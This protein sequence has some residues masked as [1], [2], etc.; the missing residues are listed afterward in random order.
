MDNEE[1]LRHFLKR[2]T[3]ELQE[4]REKLREAETADQEPIAIVGLGCRFPG[5][6][7]SPEALWELLSGGRDAITEFPDDRGWDVD[8]LHDA[9]GTTRGTSYVRHGGFLHDA[10]DFDPAFF[11]I[12]PREALVMDPQQRLMLEISW[13]AIERAGIDPAA[14]RGSSTGVFTGTNFQDYIH[15]A[16]SA[17]EGAEDYLSTANASSVLSGRVAYALGLE[18]PAIT[19]DTACSA[20]LV[21]MHLAAHALR[22]GDC[23]LALAGGATI[24]ATPTLFIA[25]SRQRGL[26]P[27]GRC[28]SFAAGAE[29][30]GWGEGAGV[31]VLERLSDAERNGHRIL[32]VMRGSAVNQD[33]ASNGLTAPSGP[34][35]ERVIRAALAGAGLTPADVD[36]VE[37]HGTGTTLGDPIEARALAATYGRDRTGEPLWLGS[38]KSNLGHTQAAAGVAGVLKMVLALQHGVL[39]ETLGVDA[40]TPALDWDSSGLALVTGTRAWPETGRPRRAGVSSF[41]LSGTNAHI[42]LEQAPAIPERESS[43]DVRVPGVLNWPLAGKNAA[44]LRAQAARLLSFVDGEV[45]PLD[46]AYS[47][48]TTRAALPHRAVVTGAGLDDL[49]QGLAALAAGNGT[50]GVAAAGAVAFLFTGQGAQRVGMGTELYQA[51]PVFAE[52][53]DAACAHLDPALTDVVRGA[54]NLDDTQYAQAA[55]FALEVALFRL[56]ESWG[57]RPDYLLGHSVG[58]IAAAHVAGVFSLED[59]GALVSA[60]GRLMQ[61]LPAGGAMLAAEIPEAEALEL[62]AG[63]EASVSLAAINGPD[64]VVLSGD[65]TAI[66]ELAAELTARGRRTK[67]LRVSHAFHS[68]LMEPMLG[69]FAAVARG[70]TYGEARIPVVSNR[71]GRV[72]TPGELQDPAYWVSHV[73]EAVRFGDGV[74]WL[75]ERDVTRFVELG[76]DGVLSAMAQQTVSDDVRCVPLLRSGRPEEQ[77]VATAVAALHVAGVPVDWA[78]FY[79]GTGAERM[80]LPTYA[81]QHERYWPEATPPGAAATDPAGLGLTAAGHPL[82][83]TAIGLADGEGYLFT[84][85]LTAAATPWLADHVIMGS[86]LLPG[87]AF[88]ELAVRAGDSVGCPQVAELTLEAP[89]VVP[90]RGGVRLQLIVGAADHAGRRPITVHSRLDDEPEDTAWERHASGVLAPGEPVTV[91]AAE[92]WP[93]AGAD[94]IDITGFYD[95]LASV[96]F[97]YGPA[98]QG[99][100]RVWRRGD[101]VFAEVSRPRQA[102]AADSYGL[103][104][105]LLDAALHALGAAGRAEDADRLLPFAWSGVTLHAAGASALRVRIDA[106]NPVSVSL[107]VSDAAG[108][109]VATVD[110]LALR[111]VSTNTGR[112]A[113]H[114]SLFTVEWVPVPAGAAPA[115]ADWPALGADFG[116]EIPAHVRYTPVVPDGETPSAVREAV[117]TALSTVQDW[118]A[119]ERFARSRLVVVTHGDLVTAPLWGL[120]GSAQAEQ[121]DRIT[122]VELDDDP[123]SAELLS[124]AVALGEPKIAIREGKLCVPRLARA[125]VTADA[126]PVFDET[127]TVLVTGGL[128]G[129][130]GQV[131]RH[132]VTEHGVRRLLLLGRRGP[133]TPGADRLCAD[134][135]EL[136]ADATALACDVADRDALT[137]VFADHEITAVVHT[138]GVLADATFPSLTGE[139]VDAVLRPKVDAAWHLHELTADRP[140]VTAFVLFSSVAGVFGAAGQGNYAAANAF[141]DALA[142]HRRTQGLPAVSLAWGAWAPWESEGGNLGMAGTL[143]DADIERMTRAGTPPLALD[144]ALSLFDAAL[145]ADDALLAPVRLDL[146]TLS[147]APEVPPLLRRLVRGS[148]RRRPKADSGLTAR[149]AALAPADRQRALV[150]LVRTHVVGLLGYSSI[151]QVE[152]AQSFADLGFDS[153]SAVELRNAVQAETGLRLP[154]TLVFDYP[155][156]LALARHLHDELVG[157]LGSLDAV[158]RAP[159]RTA[160]AVESDPVVI[161]SMGC[162]YPGGITSPDELWD[163]VVGDGDG[164]SR[165]PGDRGWPVDAIYHPDPDHAGTSYTRDG[166]FLDDVAG[167]DPGFFGIS[168][169]EAL[170]MDPQQRQLLETS[171]EALERAGIRPGT[172]RGSRTGVYAGIMYHD[173]LGA[174]VEFPADSLGYLGT[175]NAGSVLSGRISYVFGLEGPSVTVDT[176][177][178]SS[179][180][181]L[182]MAATALQR[183]ECELA[184]AGGVTVMATPGT[185]ID[186]SRQRGL[187]ADGRCKSYADSADG[188]GWSEGVGVLV[189]ERLS[190]ARRNGHPVLA[191]VRGS[192]VNSDGASNGLTAPNGPSQQRVIRQA[193]GAAGLTP[194][195]VD[196]VEGHGTGTTLGDPIEAQALLATYGQERDEFQPLL[197][198]SVKSNLGHTQAAAGVAGVIKSVLA[199]RAGIVPKSL[200]IDAPSSHVDWTAGDIQLVTDTRPWPETGRPRRAAVSSFGISGTNAHVV[201]EQAPAAEPAPVVTRDDRPAPWLLAA[202]TPEALRAQA[203]RLLTAVG[204]ADARD[205]A[206]SLAT[207]RTAFEYRAVLTGDPVAALTALA[208]GED[209]PLPATPG[210]RTAFLFT[211]QGAQ[212][213]GA[214]RELYERFPAFAAALDDVCAHLDPELGF[215]LRE[216]MFDADASLEPTDV[217][218]PA[219][220]AIEVALYRLLRS[221]GVTPDL[222]LGHSIG[223]LAAAH[224]AG[225]F[226]LAD[227]SRLVA[228][229]GRLMAALPATGA[230]VAINA[231]EEAVAGA[232]E[233]RA[234]V[235][236]AAVNGPESVVLSGDEDAVTE[237]TATFVEAGHRTSRLKVSHAFHS[238]LMDPMLD[239]F[240]AIAETIEYAPAEVPVVS[241]LTGAIAGDELGTADYWVRHVREAVRFADGVA[242][243]VAD[244]VTAFLEVGPAGVLSAMAAAVLPA[245]AV[246]V[247]ALRRDREDIE[248]VV[249]ALSALHRHG[250]DVD[251]DAYFVGGH[252]LAL[253]TYAFQHERF[254]PRMAVLPGDVGAIGLGAVAHPLLGGGIE[255]PESGGF[256]FTAR[257]S[258]ATHPWLAGHRIAGSVLLPGT[259]LLELAVCAGDQLGCPGV[260][261]LTLE[262]PLVLADETGT[263][264]QVAVGPPDEAGD[265]PVTVYSRRED[266]IDQPWTRH[267]SGTLLGT[268]EPAPEPVGRPGNADEVDLTALYDGFADQGFEYGPAFRGLTA[269]WRHGEDVYAEVRLPEDEHADAASFGLHPALLDACLHATSFSTAVRP[270]SLPFAWEGVSVHAAGATSVLVRV[271]PAG[272]DAVALQVTDFDGTPVASV[273]SLV[274]RPLPSGAVDNTADRDSLFQLD[275]IPFTPGAPETGAVAVAGVDQLG[276]AGVFPD[277]ARVSGLLA[278]D[279]DVPPFVV[280]PVAGDENAEVVQETHELT[281]HVLALLQDWLA[282]ERFTAARLV[283]VTRGATTG[284]D[285]PAAAVWGLARTAQVEHPGRIVLVDLDGTAESLAALPSALGAGEPQVT[286]V[287]GDLRAARLTR[288]EPS[289]PYESATASHELNG[290]GDPD[291]T[292]LITGGTGGLGGLLARHLVTERGARHLLLVSRRGLAADGAPELVAD[293][294]EAGADVEVRSCDIADRDALRALL[295]GIPAEHPLTAVV[296]TAGVLDDGVLGSLT[297]ERLATVLRPKVDAAWN[298]HELTRDLDLAA[299]VSFSSVAGTFGGAGQANYAAANAFLDALALRR[300]G[301]GRPAQSLGWGPWAAATGMTRALSDA[302][303][304]RMARL[305]MPVLQ[306]EQSI[307]LFDRALSTD[308]AVL[309]PVRLDLPVIRTQPEIPP[310]LRG[311]VRV[312]GRRLAG[313]GPAAAGLV[314]RLAGLSE[315]ER[316]EA[317]LDLVRGQVALVLGHADAAAIP[318]AKTFQELGFDSLT[319]VDLRNK[320]T[321]ASGVALPATTVFDYPTMTALARHLTG[322]LAGADDD[323]QDATPAVAA[324]LDEPIA[325]VAMSCRYPGGVTTPEQLWELVTGGTD[326]ITEFPSDRG[327]DVDSLYDPDPDHPGTSYTR[328]GGFLHDAAEFDAAFF[329]MS[330]REAVA[331]DTQQRLLLEVSWEAIERAGIDPRVLRGSRTGVFAGVM[332][333]DYNSL[334]SGGDLEA[335]QG[336]GSAG[337]VASGRVSY[338]LGLEGPAVTVDTACSSSL[339]ALHWAAQALRSGECTLALAGGVTVMSTPGTFVGFSR[340]RGLSADGR[341]KSF[342]DDADGVGWSEGAGML[343]LERLSDARRNGHPVLAVVKGSA[344]NSDGASNGLTAPNGPSQQRVIRQALAASG[345][346]TSDVDVVEGHGTGTTLGDPIEAQALLATYGRDRETPLLLGSVKS[347]IGHTQAAAGVAGII[348]MVEALRHG[349]VPPSLHAGEVSTHV[350]WAAGDVEVVTGNRPWPE[351]GRARRAAVSSFGISG[352]NAHTIIEQAPDTNL[353]DAPPDA[354]VVPWPLS[355]F[356]EPALR[357]QAARLAEHVADVNRVDAGYSLATGRT[358]FDQRAV[359]LSEHRGELTAALEALAAGEPHPAVVTGQAD[360]TAKLA[361]LFAG[362]GAQRLGMGRRLYARYPA[363]AQAWDAVVELLPGDWAGIVWGEDS[364]AL[365]GTASAQP[366]L[367]ALEVALYRLFESWGVRPDYVLGHSVGEIAAAHVAG[368][369]SLA[370]ACTLVGARASLMGALP[371]GGAM[372]SVRAT[373][374]EVRPLLGEDVAIAAVNGPEAVVLAGVE[375]AV[376]AVAAQFEKTTRLKVS[377]AFHSPLMDPMLDEFRAVA[378]SL[379]YASPQIPLMS[380]VTGELLDAVGPDH[381]VD[382][383]RR[384]VRFADGVTALHGRG[385][386]VFAEFGPDGVLSAMTAGT[387]P[388]D[389]VTVPLLR[390]ETPEPRAALAGLGGLHVTGVRVDW[391]AVLAG[392]RRTALPT[393]AF[394]RER[395]WPKGGATPRGDATA[396]G[397]GVGGHPM[398]GAVVRPAGSGEILLTS[399]LSVSG[400]PWLA[401]HVVGGSV[402]LPGTVF[403]ELALRAGDEAGT[404]CLEELTLTAPLV[405][406]ERGGV[407]V[408]LRVAEPGADG[409]RALTV[410]SRPEAA[411]DLAWI[412]HATGVF[413]P[414]RPATAFDAGEWP[415]AGAVE[416]GLDGHYERLTDAGLAYT[417]AFRGLTAAWQLGDDVFAD[418]ALPRDEAGEAGAFGLHP[419]LFDACLHAIGL[420]G[421]ESGA[422]ELPFAW[423][424][425]QLHATGAANVRVRISRSGAGVAIA[426]ADPAGQPVAEAASLRLRPLTASRP[427]PV[428]QEH[429]YRLTWTPLAAE[430]SG[431][432]TAGVLGDTT[433]LLTTAGIETVFADVEAAAAAAP[434]LVVLPLLDQLHD[435]AAESARALTSR[436]LELLQEWLAEDRLRDTRLVV[437]TRG[438]TDG[439]PAAAAV[440]GL[441]RSAQAEHPGRVTLV[442]LADD[443]TGL[444]AALATDE[445]QVVLRNGQVHGGRLAR[446][447]VAEA[448]AFGD[449]DGTVLITGGTGGLG[450]LFARHLASEHGM[451]RLLLVSRSGGDVDEV[452]ALIAELAAH[453]TEATVAAC[454]VA[455]RDALATLL[456]GIPAEQPLTAVV[457]SA[458]VVDD[459]VLDSLTAERFDR[460]LRPKAQGAW[461]LHELTKDLGLTSFVVFS[462]V[463][464]TVGTAG[465]ANYAAANAFL[466]ALARRRHAEGLPATSLAWGPWAAGSGMTSALTEADLARMARAGTPAIPAELGTRLFDAALA[467]GVP[468]LAPVHLD[469]PVLRAMGEVP[470]ILRGLIRVPLRRSAA[471]AGGEA[472]VGLVRR[473]GALDEAG[474]VRALRELITAQVAQVLGHADTGGLDADQTFQQLGFDS[475]TALELRNRLDGATGV[476]LS[477]TAVFDYPTIAALGGHLLEALLGSGAV[478]DET[479][480]P[481]A[482][483]GDPIVIVGMSC[484]FP[485]GVSSPEDLWQLLTEERDAIT[486]FPA[487]RG[488]DIA[489]LYHP[490]PDNP[491]TTYTREGGFLH[492]AGEFDPEFFGMNPREALATDAQQRL[493]L[494]TGWEAVEGAG[495]D[496]ATLRGSRTGVFVGVM[497]NDYGL[498]LNHLADTD[499]YESNGSSPSVASGRVA[500]TFGFE[501]PTLTVDT[502]CSSSL[503]TLHLAAQALRNGECG[504]ALAGGATVMA[505][506]GTFVGFSRQRGLATDGRCKAFSD[507]ADGLG[508]AEGV[509]ML[510]LERMSDAR[511]NGH[512]I[513]AVVRGSAINSDGA[514][515]GLTAPNGPAQQRVIRQALAAAGLSTSDIDA[516][517]AHGTGT[518]LGDPIE[519]QALIATYGRDRENPLPIGSVKS[520][521]GHTQAAAGVAGI[522]KMI[523]AMRH[524]VLPRSLHAATPSSHVDWQDSGVEVLSQ[525]RPWPDAGRVRRAA[526]S[527]FGISG[528]NAHTVLEAAPAPV[529]VPAPETPPA[530][531]PWVLSGRTSAALRGQAE[532]LLAHLP[533]HAGAATIG[534]ALAG[535]SAFPHRAVLVGEDRAGLTAA[536]AAV[537][538]GEAAPDVVTGRTFGTRAP[539]FVFPGQGSQWAGMARD[540]LAASPVFAG[541]MA[542]C[543]A[544]LS[545]FV[546][547]SLLEVLEDDEALQEVDIVQPALWAVMVSLAALWREF[548]VEPAAVVGHSQGEIAAACVAGA[549]SLSDGARVVALRSRLIR[550]KLARTGVML[551]VVAPVDDVREL[552]ADLGDEV[553]IAAVNGPKLITVSGDE[554]ALTA[555]EKRLSAAGMMRW[556]LAGVNFAAHSPQVELLEDDLLEQLAP[557]TPRSSTVRFYSSVTGGLLDTA[558]L[559]ARYWYRNIRQTVLFGDAS[560][561]MVAD[562]TAAFIEPSPSPV[563]KMALE[564]T[565]DPTGEPLVFQETLRTGEGDWRRMVTAVAGAHAQGV[566]IDWRA[567]FERAGVTA[568]VPLPTYAFQRK[569]YWPE[570]QPKA[571]P[572]AGESAADARLWSTVAAADVDTLASVLDVDRTALDSVLPA[573]TSWREKLRSDAAIDRWWYRIDWTPLKVPAEAAAP[574]RW[575]AV[576]AEGTEDQPWVGQVLGALP[577][578]VTVLPVAEPDPVALAARIDALPGE[579]DGVV[580]LLALRS[581]PL[582]GAPTAPAGMTLTA[583]LVQALIK[584]SDRFAAGV[585][586]WCLTREALGV[587]DH[588][589]AADTVE[590]AAVWGFGRTVALELSAAWGGMVDLTAEPSEGDLKNL[591]LVLTGIDGE[592]QV[593][594]RSG[595]ILGRRL[596]RTTAAETPVITPAL[597]GPGTVL[598]TGGTGALGSETARW[599]AD[600]GVKRLVLTSRRG[601]DAPGAAELVEELAGR[602]A[603]ASV[604]ACDVAERDQLAALLD[605]IPDEHPLRGV[606]HSAGVP[607]GGA[608][609]VA[610]TLDDVEAVLKSKV[611]GARLLDELVGDRELDFFVLYSS[612]AGMLGSGKQSAYAAANAYLNALAE[613]RVRRGLRGTSLGWGLWGE[614]GMA[615]QGDMLD[616]MQRHGL[617]PLAPAEAM[618]AFGRALGFQ[619][620]VL[621]ADFDWNR[622][623]LT[624]TLPRESALLR[625]LPEVRQALGA[626]TIVERDAVVAEATL[627]EELAHL[628]PA[629][630]REALLTLVRSV[631]AE[632]LGYGDGSDIEPSQAF[633]EMGV[634]SLA[635]VEVRNVLAERTGVRL[636]ST[637]VF[638][639]P[640]ANAI[641]GHLHSELFGDLDDGPLSEEETRVRKFL[642]AVSFDQLRS[643]GLMDLLVEAVDRSERTYD[644]E[645]AAETGDDG[646]IGDMDAD[647]LVRFVLGGQD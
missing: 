503:V 36:A 485:G 355:A 376:L 435:N 593:C 302:D 384:T 545:E 192:A 390:K 164:I 103:H 583:V 420:L 636:P 482:V 411:D 407:Q 141:L 599:L 247:P 125:A 580:S 404:P 223:E 40:P 326:A 175:G 611:A 60:R 453:G 246:A 616:H 233:G 290:L 416:V 179:L 100:E 32:A 466:D 641:A 92:A 259:A 415:P 28:R 188:V 198:G 324:T 647:D 127:S 218:Q 172:L 185:F 287:D 383:V 275:W 440:W 3:V 91:P 161:V 412:Q 121:P 202:R 207:T 387:L 434:N 76:P 305:G 286:L 153:L 618:T 119:D 375:D 63:R 261:E 391:A 25:F 258:L 640:T 298:L 472:A 337:S 468:D 208:A 34:A 158:D 113:R 243:L 51:F 368:V 574:S 562:G 608:D 335:Y 181:A 480:V 320:L 626:D 521:I 513:L 430:P 451:R 77:T 336:N 156:V 475:L 408:Q 201:L 378:E 143:A 50:T 128:G 140:G 2:V 24:M 18:G 633:R 426:V 122:L 358:A 160:A 300:T 591:P 67:R 448:D 527:S 439:D 486:A 589:A 363:F 403:A 515:N 334:V 568:G 396:A 553:S 109:P 542:E 70:I 78:G 351:T 550:Q 450:A 147:A 102:T 374:E 269:A 111:P 146:D 346:S 306:P 194:S 17:A 244:G 191:V 173:Y 635:A 97:G 576:V 196:V 393:Y 372:V 176:A 75:A 106:T 401:G 139:Q 539:A 262:A 87:T 242:A 481:A 187:A 137:S 443:T 16:A 493:L 569:N 572:E 564:Q 13:E 342:S 359:V 385:V 123:A 497:Y 512:E 461:N 477:A 628:E 442:D 373:E 293:L 309:L 55:L 402:V 56:A 425:V 436:T 57:L 42:I 597:A 253:P 644:E 496:P 215:S 31:L 389:T 340:Q 61:A 107:N 394:Q 510:L 555:L 566:T 29:G 541:T 606:V 543:A 444:A 5:G 462:S 212:R 193:L 272:D 132:L 353:P 241:N 518:K 548:G 307:R 98:F 449:P 621:A 134:L 54:G 588:P 567:H 209:V 630:R 371:A 84:G 49:R 157:S 297:P 526:V 260:G 419:A 321:A 447:A 456:A 586:L 110:S 522:I 602:G 559:D 563:L 582:P 155:T 646:D 463:A 79:A 19:V 365:A 90:E 292:V 431:F 579:F 356:T 370:D 317:V 257:V 546:D 72:A 230:M 413:G 126:T 511:R 367:F 186:F 52:A 291:G 136:G 101:E 604:V 39:P 398:V 64:S 177:C 538:A 634:D 502:A 184:L 265:R 519:A 225:V 610:L 170:A 73:R 549:L 349:V 200:H 20:S 483:A 213:A 129:L 165:F 228:A 455:D 596:R 7:S 46:L 338:V 552:L 410:H 347:N 423:E 479:A 89:L 151:S 360:E 314:R 133:D 601:P 332:Y 473:L 169:R 216:R 171:W 197:L 235:S 264:V 69:E 400:H 540:L 492:N 154:A 500:Y 22:R 476:R 256:L 325:I 575:L 544:A 452:T 30:T 206:W 210:A 21:A 361:A 220:F 180:V 74:R 467:A 295:E 222:L 377:H 118:L 381:W 168:P 35:Q 645:S 219:L 182:H 554:G 465:Q 438:A 345:L 105:A 623:A 516:I 279:G 379:T 638:D 637:L 104:P 354:G 190:D 348:K 619:G 328:H 245:E 531:V 66:D 614:T 607:Q 632:L 528:T 162:R 594:L 600:A 561:A 10:G 409:R 217:A 99:L 114:E 224:V 508:F 4:T 624:F 15:L 405:L 514:S 249:D 327:W 80:D 547:W 94:E 237:I 239:D 236:I 639:Y 629:E 424:G 537:A 397:L 6:A 428:G 112:K 234:G 386:R 12:S 620:S 38:V 138:A 427:G 433:E 595:R 44:G 167:F 142:D 459:G 613:D 573:L 362:Q 603:E 341:C 369:L 308:R 441:V 357:A 254:W 263:H 221:W 395:F 251:W 491:G 58:E 152:P 590:Q 71:T 299:F 344:V 115:V 505:T 211:G 11:G 507:D 469:L 605:A 316:A 570:A 27:D 445:P 296:Q 310:L 631:A 33:G 273:R 312:S 578:A 159:V 166:G 214:G 271:S 489:S 318:A 174:N 534:R 533:E 41:G 557:I 414:A 535:R 343:L 422:A 417:G 85:R 457:H 178:S 366:A 189:L 48:G 406:P 276:V 82:L 130:G 283:L 565:M 331:T 484:R 446:V 294:T 270:G 627:H 517:E 643:L 495:I 525:A 280:Y 204:D 474:R 274:L 352:T 232:I 268:A 592:D 238:P 26:A 339:V 509:G 454:D 584:E 250:V 313:G 282:D 284:A 523:L 315:H 86:I 120:L 488:W 622:F 23:S 81:F 9:D 163:F 418:V 560:A 205:V 470:P 432:A 183:G 285:L 131:A 278:F 47:L 499:G 88:L 281:T 288:A 145:G 429:L 494:E 95:G 8:R 53:W 536:L 501:G 248:T 301:E 68:P 62:L 149:L 96:G 330:P 364:R 524:G 303:I 144:Q 199:M 421:T 504:L 37:A 581:E 350:D 382:N 571:A 617:V 108:E 392:G 437:L 124:A 43:P 45:A 399:R 642:A 598:I 195:E 319:A 277:A 577:G 551:S 59:A 490:D 333:N 231:T 322:Q 471:A 203:E 532:R 587:E 625:E 506:P 498:T 150:D 380:T 520:N 93:P 615:M 255:L 117:H 229:R 266:A 609:V 529:P 1:K 487:N 329:G 304:E 267:A 252:Q 116:P 83:G 311:L 135:A 460:V 556:R 558:E 464:G 240:R 65:E 289:F 226:S 388:S 458:G 323:H 478:T 227:A 14:L 530:I 612:V 148:A 585:R